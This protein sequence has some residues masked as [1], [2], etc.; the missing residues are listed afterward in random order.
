MDLSYYRMT[1]GQRFIYKISK[2]F[3]NF[4]RGFVGFFGRIFRAIAH[5]FVSIGRGFKEFGQNFWYGDALT[6]SSH[7]IMGLSHLFRGQI[8]RGIIY[9]LLE[10]AFVLYMVMFGGNCLA[11]CFENFFSGGNVGRTETYDFWNPDEGIYD[12]MVGDN[13]FLILLYGIL[14]LFV[15]IFFI[16]C[17]ISCAKESYELEQ[18]HIIG[19][20]PQ[21]FRR[22][23][24][25]LLDNKFHLTLLSLPMVGLF[26]FTIVP[27]VT[28]IL[29]AFTNYD[30]AHEVPQHLF[31]WV[32]FDNFKDLFAGNSKLG[33]TFWRVLG[34]TL[35]WAVLATF[36]S[37]ILGMLL[38]MLI[39]RKGIKLKKLYR[40]LF[41][42]TIAVPQFVSLL[43]MSKMLDTGGG[44]LGSG[45]GIIT[46]LIE[47]IFDYHLKFGIDINTTRICIVI[48]NMW[49]GVPYSMLMCS[50]ILMNI[51]NDLYE[52]ARIDGAS[53]ARRFFKITLPYMLFV[54]GPYLITQFIGNINNFN[55]IYLLSGGGPGDIML[56]TDGAKG[57]DLLITWLYKL[58]LGTDRN[59]KLASVIGILVF[60]IS[61]VFS[62]I[63]Y[64]KSSAVKGEDNFQ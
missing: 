40:T 49:I 20:K 38:A 60:V 61:S 23:I 44:V 45:G 15:I 4:G 27:L 47:R 2:F 58:S 3:K 32:G 62:L 6:K 26:V 10:T 41:V 48:V 7:A 8:V 30:A 51:P 35:M 28:M 33:A 16:I 34:W 1:P 5:F 12:K 31:Q 37:Y 11:M 64:N 63:V 57:T 25:N 59:Y 21:T 22:D 54:T 52:S 39:N 29:I 56:Y 19:K 18:C 13:S 14:T 50:G 53:P 17:Y 42:A 46:Q 24:N 9:L 43:I 55:V 36:T